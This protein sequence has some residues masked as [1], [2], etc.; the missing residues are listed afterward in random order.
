MA[1]S[2][3]CFL[4]WWSINFTMI[5][6][7]K[8]KGPLNPLQDVDNNSYIP[9]NTDY[10][11]VCKI[12]TWQDNKKAAYTLSFDDA[13][14]SHFQIAGPL[15]KQYGIVG[16]FNLDTKS[17]SN[18]SFWQK[19]Y[20]DGNEIASHTWSHARCTELSEE[21]L[22][23][24]IQSAKSDIEQ[25][26]K[27]ISQ[28]QSFV[29]PY[30]A[31]NAFVSKIVLEQHRSARTAKMGSNESVLSDEEFGTIKAV[32]INQPYDMFALNSLI[33]ETIRA[34]KWIVFIFHSVSE[35]EEIAENVIPLSLFKQHLD[36]LS[37]LRTSLWIATQGQ[38][39][40]YIK[41]RQNTEMNCKVVNGESIE[42]AISPISSDR[43]EMAKLTIALDVPMNWLGYHLI[44]KDAQMKVVATV[45]A[46]R[47]TV[48]FDVAPN[49]TLNI[50]G[51]R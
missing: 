28:I 45:V 16:S 44:I 11:P 51:V 1:R 2:L 14:S 21:D 40:D 9:I 47:D 33:Q 17:I 27:G 31:Y 15:L 36:F 46:S 12:C 8:E 43:V 26:I 42:V 5:S 50:Y 22:R 19:L 39:V 30:G 32:W 7:Q 10:Q 49:N 6:C 23:Y 25:H 4:L 34:G 41:A 20:D 13:R 35:Q 3:L 24:E 18:W 38:V 48:F 37:N 29:Y